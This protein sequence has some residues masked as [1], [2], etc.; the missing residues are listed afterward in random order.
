VD[1]ATA[2]APENGG[3]IPIKLLRCGTNTE[4]VTVTWRTEG[5]TAKPG[6]DYL[7]A[8]GTLTFAAHESVAS[9]ELEVFDNAVPDADRT[10]RMRLQGPPPSS[11][12]YP[13]IELTIV[14]DDLGFLP[15]GI[16]HFP[17][18]RVWLRPTG[19]GGFSADRV[20]WS[21]NLRDWTKLAPDP[22]WWNALFP[23]PEVIDKTAPTNTVRFYRLRLP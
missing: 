22:G 14:N 9:I 19:G 15:G 20:S 5:G 8:S 16:K 1:R 2:W 23:D 13:P 3:K 6:V 10:V 12:E 4:P 17:N 18:G 7:P 21:D 11:Q